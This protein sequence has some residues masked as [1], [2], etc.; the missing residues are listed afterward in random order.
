[1]SF[2]TLRG[3]LPGLSRSECNLLYMKETDDWG[4]GGLSQRDEE[5]S[6]TFQAGSDS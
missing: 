1:M 4:M 6:K 2:Q 5:E 3:I